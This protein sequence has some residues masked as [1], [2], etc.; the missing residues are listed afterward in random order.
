[1]IALPLNDRECLGALTDE[2]AR[3][4][5][6]RDP[7]LLAMAAPHATTEELAAWIRSLPQRDDEGLPCDGPKLEACDPPQRIDLA[8]KAPNCFERSAIFLG[9]AE[10]IE[11]GVV[12][13]LATART[14]AGLHTYPIEDGVPIVLD[15]T[16]SR[17]ALAAS[18]FKTS[19][20]RNGGTVRMS[21]EELVDWMAVVATEPAERFDRGTSRIENAHRAI[22]ALLRGRPLCVADVRDVAF[23]LALADREARQWGA[24][25]PRMVSV[26]AHAIDQLDRDAAANWQAGTP[27]VASYTSPRN[28]LEL[29]LGDVRIKPDTRLLSALGRVGGRLGYTAGMEALRLKL[30]AMGVTPPMLAAI[31]Q[32]LQREGLSLGPL[33]H[34]SP[35]AEAIA[36]SLLTPKP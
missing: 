15:P 1:M 18:L 11:P 36:G 26:A 28:E 35:I 25:G 17:N 24:I 34:P 5:R 22:R 13:R 10:H 16:V 27:P 30:A 2:I 33:A 3:R 7:E 21:P 9:A 6:D 31:D 8:S 14:P 12:R 29:S 32:E 20:A 23:L 4:V 19:H